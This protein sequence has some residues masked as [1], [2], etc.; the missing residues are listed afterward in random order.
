MRYGSG[1]R[2]RMSGKSDPEM[3]AFVLVSGLILFMLAIMILL[4]FLVETD[5]T[6]PKVELG[7]EPGVHQI[8]RS[9]PVV[10]SDGGRPC[11]KVLASFF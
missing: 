8:L 6:P 11:E 1:F 7:V 4:A 10:S 3:I 9:T 5:D 2:R